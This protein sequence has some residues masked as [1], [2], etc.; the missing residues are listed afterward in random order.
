MTFLIDSFMALGPSLAYIPQYMDIYR[1]RNA[2]GFDTRVSLILMVAN[3]LR[4]GF[5]FGKRF[6]LV[7]LFQS[8]CKRS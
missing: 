3:I 7:L 5:W 4:I 8:I 6:D 2:D 1:L